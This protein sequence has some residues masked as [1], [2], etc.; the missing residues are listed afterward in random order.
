MA[1]KKPARAV[2]APAATQAAAP[3]THLSDIDRARY[4][5]AH[6]RAE[7]EVGKVRD[8]SRNLQDAQKA[9]AE[10]TRG[11]VAIQNEI[12]AKY[13]LTTED[14][15]MVDTGEILRAPKPATAPKPA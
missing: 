10:A 5:A 1:Q 15:V 14:R 13:G 8:A 6:Y 3:V 9:N 7:A 11:Y 12:V 4:A 2:P